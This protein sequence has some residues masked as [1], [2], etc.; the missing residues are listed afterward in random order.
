LEGAVSDAKAVARQRAIDYMSRLLQMNPIHEGEEIILARVTSLGLAK[1][2]AAAGV[3][4]AEAPTV[5]RRKLLEQLEA[6]RVQFWTMPIDRLNAELSAFKAHGFADVESAVARL[7]VVAAHRAEFPKL[8]GHKHFDGQ[9]FSP[10]KEILTRSARDTSIIKEQVLS[11]FRNRAR[12]KQCRRMVALL[13]KELPA[14]YSLEADWLDTLQRQKAKPA[15]LVAAGSVGETVSS[16]DGS[17]WWV[18]ILVVI[19]VRGLI[20]VMNQDS[21]PKTPKFQVDH[22]QPFKDLKL[23]ENIPN[24]N[25]YSRPGNESQ[26]KNEVREKIEEFKRRNG[27]QNWR[28][29]EEREPDVPGGFARPRTFDPKTPGPPNVN[30]N[31]QGNAPNGR[32]P[33]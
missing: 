15:E 6:I 33:F 23:P 29:G 9:F 12:R 30:P 4:T 7:R 31:R 20:G 3:A 25:S 21:K 8:A 19:A 17:K 24:I 16:G 5:E 18:V 1:K 11:T 28:P 22:S 26:P 32:S 27:L 2:E 14:V 13:K 10:F